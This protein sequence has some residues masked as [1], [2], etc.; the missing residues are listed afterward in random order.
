M[1]AGK[2]Y[3]LVYIELILLGL[4]VSFRGLADSR[5]I[6]PYLRAAIYLRSAPPLVSHPRDH[7]TLGST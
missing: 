2:F 6:C 1:L 4:A 5:Y 3:I 7:R